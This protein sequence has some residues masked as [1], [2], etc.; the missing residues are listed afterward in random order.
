MTITE[1]RATL[2]NVRRLAVLA[3]FTLA[4][5]WGWNLWLAGGAAWTVFWAL[6]LLDAVILYRG[7]YVKCRSCG[8]YT[9]KPFYTRGG[10][11]LCEKCVPR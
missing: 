4:L 2:R 6:V 1:F 7:G 11:A 5:K 9:N 3:L 10:S 8:E